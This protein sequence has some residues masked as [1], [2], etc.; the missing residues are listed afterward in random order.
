MLDSSDV[1]ALIEYKSNGDFRATAKIVKIYKGHLNI[2][3]EIWVSGFSNRYGPIDKVHY[4]EK[5]LVFLNLN[6]PTE[7]RLEYWNEELKEKPELQGFVDAFKNRKAYYVWSPTSGDLK[8]KGKKIQYDLIQT[9]FY[10]NE[11]YFSLSQFEDF[12]KNYYQ[13]SNRDNFCYS[14]FNRI[15]PANE[16]NNKSQ[17]LMMLNLMGFNHYEWRRYLEGIM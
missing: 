13:S 1:V 12:L 6:E 8:I 16:K 5:Y 11:K 4:G 15:S 9:T 14:L 3:D 17:Y 10:K 2:G 7:R